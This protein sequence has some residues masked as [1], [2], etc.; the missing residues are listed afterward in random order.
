MRDGVG[1]RVVFSGVTRKREV[2][3]IGL[4]SRSAQR[5]Q[6]SFVSGRRQLDGLAL[7]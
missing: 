3:L 5:V 7:K 1:K 2:V 4:Y 6:P